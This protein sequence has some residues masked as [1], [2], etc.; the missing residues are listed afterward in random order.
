MGVVL[1]KSRP[2]MRNDGFVGVALPCLGVVVAGSYFDV[3]AMDLER[4]AHLVRDGWSV[5]YRRCQPAPRPRHPQ[6]SVTAS[7]P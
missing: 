7:C 6:F 1:W 5:R 3:S 2:Y 4:V